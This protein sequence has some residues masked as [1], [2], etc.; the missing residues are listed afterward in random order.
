MLLLSSVL[1]LVCANM[2]RVW[3]VLLALVVPLLNLVLLT[4]GGS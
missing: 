3:L 1:L 4:A 2:P